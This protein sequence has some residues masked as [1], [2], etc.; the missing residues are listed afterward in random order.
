M[1]FGTEDQKYAKFTGLSYFTDASNS[2]ILEA[3]IVISLTLHAQF[4]VLA[5]LYYDVSTFHVAN[6]QNNS[7]M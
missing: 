2:G 7:C 4:S 6:L 3:D 1:P 5:N